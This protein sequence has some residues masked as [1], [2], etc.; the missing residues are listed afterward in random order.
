MSMN[1]LIVDDEYEIL[2][3]LEEMFRYEF[4][5]AIDVYTAASAYDALALLNQMKFDVVLTD[6]RMPGM[7]GIELFQKIKSNWPRCKT[8]FLTGYPNFEDMYQIINHKDVRYMLK[9]EDDEIIMQTV[10]M[11]LT[12]LQ[13]EMEQEVQREKRRQDMEKVGKW[14]RKEFIGRLIKGELALLDKDEFSR[15]AAEADLPLTMDKGFLLFLV[16][17]DGE[18]LHHG[19]PTDQYVLLERVNQIIRSNLPPSISH[20]LCVV[21]RQ[22]GLGFV[23]HT[24]DDPDMAKLFAIVHGALEYAQSFFERMSERSFSVAIESTPLNFQETSLMFFRM[25]QILS[26]GLGR[27]RAVIAH[28]ETVHAVKTAKASGKAMVKIPMLKSQLELHRRQEYFE[29]LDEIG[30]ELLACPSTQDS[31]GMGLYYS[32]SVLLLQ[33]I[34]ENQLNEP[35]ASRMGLHK[36]T[37][38]DDHLSWAAALEYL[39]DVSAVVFELLECQESDL[40]DSALKRICDYIAAHLDGDLSLT[41]LADVGGFNSSYLSRLFKQKY[42]VTITEYINKKRMKQAAKLLKTTNDKIQDIAERCGYLSSHSFSRA[43]R[44]CYSTSPAEYREISRKEHSPN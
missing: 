30:A 32:V 20:Y 44:S 22:W 23:Q 34:N 26:G 37:R 1:L 40:S 18:A 31:Y 3:W 42:D 28:A 6:I 21:D 5:P 4:E 13:E 8:I 25:K 12:E 9:S 14:I 35:L 2:M 17:I 16:R 33:F 27:E 11:V 19:Q 39:Y 29:L 24:A 38:M 7:D 15:Q 43:F 36:L 41:K 10:R